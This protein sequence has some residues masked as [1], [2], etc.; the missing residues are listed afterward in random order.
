MNTQIVAIVALVIFAAAMVVIGILTSKKSSTLDGFLL[1]GR[2]IGA[3]LTAFSYGTTYFSAVIFIGYA[4][5]HGWDVGLGAMWI[6]VGNALIGAL[7]AW[8]VLA[9]KTRNMTRKLDSRT[10]PEFF[11]SR[12]DCKGMKAYSAVIIF[13]FLLPYAATVYKGLG[14]LFGSIFPNDILG[15]SPTT[16]CMIIVAVLAAAYL[17]L[18]G[19]IASAISNLV[20]GIL[21]IAG[22]IIMCVA[23]VNNPAVGG[24]GNA[25]KTLGETN[26]TL[27]NIFGGSNW[28]FLLCNILLTSFGTWGLPQMVHKYYAIKDE[29]EIKKGSVISTIFCLIIGCGAYF[30]GTLGRFF[31]PATE[32]GAPDLAGGY[33]SIVPSMLNTA[34]SASFFGNILLSVILL[35]VLSSSMSTLSSVVLTSSTSISVDLTGLFRKGKDVDQKKQMLFT[36]LLCFLF[37]VLSLIFALFNFS[38]IVSIMSLSWGVISGSFLGPYFWGLYS[39][40]TTRAGAWCGL[41]SGITVFAVYY[42][43]SLVVPTITFDVALC[44]VS[45]MAVSFIIV[46][47]VSLFTGKLPEKTVEKAFN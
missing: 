4:G 43:L 1:G 32:A 15:M 30:A 38:I 37:I 19:Y 44:G 35:C 31:V 36:R 2:K 29:Y 46:P 12:Y 34:F 21:M 33:D 8:V 6:G 23:L 22:V 25:I 40:K 45:A 20:Q 42:V 17:V 28:S 11:S 5:K 41:L 3:W 47:V 24:I 10:M 26:P 16:V 9:K 14:S 18:G 27:T 13:I 39:K 7:L